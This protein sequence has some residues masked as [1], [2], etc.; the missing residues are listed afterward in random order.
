M[1]LYNDKGKIPANRG[2]KTSVSLLLNHH[3][4]R[5]PNIK[6]TFIE[7]PVYVRIIL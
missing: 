5:L 2:H 1:A 7:Y 3:Q 4:R 6:P